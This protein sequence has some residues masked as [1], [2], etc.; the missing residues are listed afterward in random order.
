MFYHRTSDE[1]G[2]DGGY[3][4]TMKQSTMKNIAD[5]HSVSAQP[6]II[7]YHSVDFPS[8][9]KRRLPT[10]TT[11]TTITATH[12]YRWHSPNRL[13]PPPAAQ[14]TSS[15]PRPSPWYPWPACWWR[16][17]WCRA[18]SAPH[19]PSE[20]NR[21]VDKIYSI[22][23]K[24]SRGTHAC[25]SFKGE[26]SEAQEHAQ[27]QDDGREWLLVPIHN[28]TLQHNTS[29]CSLTPSASSAS[30]RHE[31]CLNT[32]S[33][34][35][36]PPWTCITHTHSTWQT[37]MKA[38]LTQKHHE[39]VTLYVWNNWS[40]IR[41]QLQPMHFV[42]KQWRHDHCVCRLSVCVSVSAYLCH[43]LIGCS[44]HLR[45]AGAHIDNNK[46]G[47]GAELAKQLV[48]LHHHQG[49]E[50]KTCRVYD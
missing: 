26:W 45:Y 9:H 10:T 49:R 1:G 23:S 29:F 35:F 27:T 41:Q 19:P 16:G 43:R 21:K 46:H 32:R 7:L 2:V 37:E 17:R 39:Q 25:E 13:A 40:T 31:M 50:G 3:T 20:Q 38:S 30:M 15:S 8:E 11:T 34:S 14:Q 36:P 47:I 48:D 33:I 42:A 18:A 44:G 4:M 12:S 22:V 6:I 24:D 5:A 28:S